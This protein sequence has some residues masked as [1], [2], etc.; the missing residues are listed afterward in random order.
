MP[1]YSSVAQAFGRALVRFRIALSL[2]TS[3]KNRHFMLIFDQKIEDFAFKLVLLERVVSELV[4]P[5]FEKNRAPVRDIL[6][7]FGF[8]S[9]L[10]HS[11]T[12]TI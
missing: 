9:L 2:E 4:A 3:S 5:L 11:K 10:K 12:E 1:V 7:N 8:C 6:K